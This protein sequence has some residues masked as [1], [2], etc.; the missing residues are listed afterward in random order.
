MVEVGREAEQGEQKVPKICACLLHK[1]D[2]V[3]LQIFWFPLYFSF[4]A[5]SSFYTSFLNHCSLIPNPERVDLADWKIKNQCETSGHK[6]RRYTRR[7]PSYKQESMKYRQT[8]IM[9][10]FPIRVLQS[11]FVFSPQVTFTIK[12]ILDNLQTRKNWETVQR[13]NI[14][15]KYIWED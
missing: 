13:K 5:D 9:A 2:Q 10:F 8:C 11:Q 12:I 15:L 14:K 4:S 3:H 7:K 6:Q 1:F